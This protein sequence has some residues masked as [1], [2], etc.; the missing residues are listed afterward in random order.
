M[1]H[2]ELAEGSAVKLI[3][4]GGVG[5]IVA[6]YLALFLLPFAMFQY[7][8]GKLAERTGPYKPLILGS[9]L[10]GGL[11]CLVGYSE[12]FMLWWVIIGL[13]LFHVRDGAIRHHRSFTDTHR[14]FT[15]QR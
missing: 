10:Y 7:F 3:G 6:R 14:L 9:L 8:T 4:L 5:G 15:G 12:A 1:T 11:L 13:G 2:G